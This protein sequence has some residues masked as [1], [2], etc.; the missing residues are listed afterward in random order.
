V[1]WIGPGGFMSRLSKRVLETALEGE[2]DGHLG[3]AKHDASGR[4]G[5]NSR[6]GTRTK[7]VLT[8]ASAPSRLMCRVIVMARSNRKSCVNVNAAWTH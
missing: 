1:K 2:S 3:Y 5:G 4:D 7:T 6:N 8:E